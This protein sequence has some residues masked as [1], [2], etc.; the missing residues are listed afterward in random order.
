MQ[1][2]LAV[3][4]ALANP[5]S[6][7]T[8]P[9]PVDWCFKRHFPH[10]AIT[11]CDVLLT[12]RDELLEN[13]KTTRDTG[14]ETTTFT[15]FPGALGVPLVQAD[16]VVGCVGPGFWVLAEHQVVVTFTLV[17]EMAGKPILRT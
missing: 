6:C 8:T 16:Q 3:A 17:G 5:S 4:T 13:G 7:E 11:I 10:C 2:G 12:Q 14:Y 15:R 1:E 9:L